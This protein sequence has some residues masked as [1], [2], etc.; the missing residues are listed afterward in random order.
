MGKLLQIWQGW[1]VRRRAIT[2]GVVV[3]AAAGLGVLAYELLKRPPDVTNEDV[4]FA[5]REQKEPKTKPKDETFDWPTYGFN[6]ARTRYVPTDKVVPPF[7]SSDW[8]FQAGKLLEFSPIIVDDVL[9]VQDIET[10]VYAIDTKRGKLLWDQRVGTRAASSLAYSENGLFV[11]TLE[12]GQAVAMRPRDGKVLWRTQ[13]P[14]RSESSPLAFKDELVIFGCECGDVIALD[15]KSGKVEWSVSTNGEI[16]GGL[17]QGKGNVYGGNYGGEVFSI[18]AKTGRQ[19]WRVTTSGGS[20]GRGG[21][22][23]STPAVAFGRVYLGSIDSRVYSFDMD[24]G[25][26]AWSKSTGAEVYSGPAVAD[27]EGT[28]GTVY[29]G[30]AD[31]NVYALDAKTGATRWQQGVG[32]QVTGAGSVIGDVFYVSVIG[33]AVGTI[34]FDIENGKRVYEH[35][36]GEYNPAITDG[37]RL[38]LTGYSEI[39][40]FPTED[41]KPDGKGKKKGDKKRK[42]GKNKRGKKQGGGNG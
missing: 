31:G 23:Y 38:F 37:E 17:A 41:A 27:T 1:S 12:P 35:E 20:F 33:D 39:R 8:S 19:E 5:A 36:L 26:I 21:G 40:P 13:L 29:I 32:G 34:G 25:R 30:S 24:D 10:K 14:G 11:T 7:D 2:V 4:E 22:V 42:R 6:D 15:Q 3:V 9:Y 28:R 18:D 16:K